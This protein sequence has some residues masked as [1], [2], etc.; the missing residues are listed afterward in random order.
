[1][2]EEKYENWDS[3]PNSDGDGRGTSLGVSKDACLFGLEYEGSRKG[4]EGRRR[5]C[6]CCSELEPA[7]GTC[8][9]GNVPR[10]R[11]KKQMKESV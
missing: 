10:L 11:P 5:G 8:G 3:C 1:M 9:G 6:C 7:P 4:G 2:G